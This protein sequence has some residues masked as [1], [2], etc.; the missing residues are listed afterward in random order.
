MIFS[1]MEVVEG[2]KMLV[3]VTVKDSQTGVQNTEIQTKTVFAR[4]DYLIDLS[5]TP[6]YFKPGQ[7]FTVRVGNQKLN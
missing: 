6:K 1:V 2:N 4:D 7:L 3:E 5:Q